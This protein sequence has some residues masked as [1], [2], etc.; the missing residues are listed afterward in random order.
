MCR[1]NRPR[2]LPAADQSSAYSPP[3]GAPMADPFPSSYPS[4]FPATFSAPPAEQFGFYSP[5]AANPLD[6]L[7]GSMGM[8]GEMGSDKI[9]AMSPTGSTGGE[10]GEEPPLLEGTLA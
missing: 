6:P 3:V 4:S 5:S 8:G 10:F 1:Y 9:S 7:S 2:P